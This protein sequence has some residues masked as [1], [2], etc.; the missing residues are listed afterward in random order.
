MAEE[1]TNGVNEKV[2]YLLNV[3][4]IDSLQF[5]CCDKAGEYEYMLIFNDCVRIKIRGNLFTKNRLLIPY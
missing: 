1:A 5:C 2:L 3:I 4:N